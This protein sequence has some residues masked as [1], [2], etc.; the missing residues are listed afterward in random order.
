MCSNVAG[1]DQPRCFVTTGDTLDLIKRFLEY[2]VEFSK[3]SYSLLLEQFSTVF[4][5]VDSCCVHDDESDSEPEET[6]GVTK[7]PHPL[8]KLK[9]KLNEYLHELPVLGFNVINVVKKYLFLYL[10]KH[11]E[12]RF[13]I[14]RNNNHMCLKTEHLKFL[15]I[16]NCL[17]PGF[18]YDAFIK[19]YECPQ[20]KG[21]FPYEWVDC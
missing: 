6:E 2:L 1:F 9:E 21:Y 3:A 5:Q 14:K 12:V 20:T 17:A 19:A 7:K 16:T 8:E 4:D 11:V 13:V 10:V 18:S 15:D